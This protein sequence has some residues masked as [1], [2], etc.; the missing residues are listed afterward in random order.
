MPK[1]GIIRFDRSALENHSDEYC[2]KE[3][4]LSREM[5]DSLRS[6]A[7]C[8]PPNYVS[9][10]RRIMNDA[11]RM[12]RYFSEM[13]DALLKVGQMV[14]AESRS[15]HDQLEAADRSMKDLLS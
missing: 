11:D 8:A 10:A 2:R 9:R 1:T 3:L 15:A 7:S 12:S 5:T 6:A 14:D 13:R 4:R